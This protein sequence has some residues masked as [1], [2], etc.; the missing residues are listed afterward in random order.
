MMAAAKRRAGGGA[1]DPYWANT[2]LLMHM[3]DTN[4][5][6]ETGRV[7]TSS[8]ATIS[9]YSG[10]M[11]AG[12][13]SFDGL[14]QDIAVQHSSLL[15]LG[16][17]DFTIEA[18]IKLGPWLDGNG[19]HLLSKYNQGTYETSYAIYRQN[20][21]GALVLYASA[22]GSGWSLINGLQFAS[23]LDETSWYSIAAT[24]SGNVWRTYLNGALA[25]STTVAGTIASNTSPLFVSKGLAPWPT[26]WSGL[27]DEL[28]ITKGVARYTSSTYDVAT[29]P[30]PNQ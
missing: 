7:I 15:N 13:G 28:R 18:R 16:A 3:D 6:E 19:H 20:T 17:E 21:S 30:F 26:R 2:V 12:S 8:N 14:T 24:R 9:T 22:S 4:F 5:T 10:T 11:G 1:S 29:E 27:I 23:T 25:N